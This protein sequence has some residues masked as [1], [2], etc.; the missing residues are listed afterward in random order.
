MAKGHE[1]DQTALAKDTVHL[2]R[3]IDRVLAAVADFALCLPIL[4]AHLVL[5]IDYVDGVKGRPEWHPSAAF[6][7]IHLFF[8]AVAL[9]PT[10]ISAWLIA[11]RGYSIG[12]RLLWIKVVRLDSSP[13]G[14]VRGVLLRSWIVAILLARPEVWLCYWGA[15]LIMVL[16]RRDR[17]CLHDL[18]F[19]TQVVK[20]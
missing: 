9:G 10:M 1:M 20:A 7:G 15:N 2:A 18:A 6:W 14:F 17:R 19:R 8:F 13:V 5:M 3:P 11:K 16:V 4:L 12:K